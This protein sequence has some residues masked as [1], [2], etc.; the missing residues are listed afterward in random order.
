MQKKIVLMLLI[1]V[2]AVGGAFAQVGMSAGVGGNFGVHMTSYSHP[3]ADFDNPKPIVGV[4]FNAFFDATYVMVKAGMF[5][6]G[7]SEEFDMGNKKQTM[8]ITGT[9]LSLGVLGKYPVDMGG[10]TL[11]PM[12]GFEYNMLLSMKMSMGDDSET[13]KRADQDN[14]SD[15]DM[16]ILQLG[17]GA[18]FNLTDKIYVRPNLLWGIDLNRSKGEKD[19]KDLRTFKHK[20]DFG[21]A[22]GFRF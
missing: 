13:F 17:V 3:D 10:F 4:G 5:I 12:L 6:G 22:V 2:F 14:A 21:L 7:N 19:T 9:Y 18:D 16:L 20:L 11:F 1:T 8:N 15:S